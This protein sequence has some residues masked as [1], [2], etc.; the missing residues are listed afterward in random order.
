MAAPYLSVYVGTTKQRCGVLQPASGQR[1]VRQRYGSAQGRKLYTLSVCEVC[2]T[3]KE[4]ESWT[5]E[6]RETLSCPKCTAL[7]LGAWKNIESLAAP[8]DQSVVLD[9]VIAKRSGR[10]RKRLG[11]K[12]AQAYSGIEDGR[13]EL[14][15]LTQ[16]V[17]KDRFFYKEYMS[18]LEW[19]RT[20]RNYLA[21]RERKCEKCGIESPL[22][23]H[24]RSYARLGRER[25]DD[26]RLLCQ[27]CHLKLHRYQRESGFCLETATDMF[28]DS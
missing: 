18:S 25:H 24:H 8:L 22:H 16:S 21:K 1:R 27:R 4:V 28:L 2:H 9:L 26:L 10:S 20:R 7:I 5:W 23:V 11:Q 12:I 17:L 19:R 13:E 6:T 3:N 15:S 14:K